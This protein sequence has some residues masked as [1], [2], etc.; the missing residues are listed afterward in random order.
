MF[1]VMI[2]QNIGFRVSSAFVICMCFS[3]ATA[4]LYSVL[5]RGHFTFC[6]CSLIFM[7]SLCIFAMCLAS[8]SGLLFVFV[9]FSV[10]HFHLC[11]GML[12][13]LLLAFV[14]PWAG[15]T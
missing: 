5:H 4:L 1:L 3:R 14:C 7:V 13:D 9:Q 6:L 10:W 12:S 15:F 2:S 8:V 11:S